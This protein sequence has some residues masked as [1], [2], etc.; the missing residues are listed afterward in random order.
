M[1]RFFL[2]SFS[3]FWLLILLLAFTGCRSSQSNSSDSEDI[4]KLTFLHINDVYEISG[5]SGG[6]YGNLARVAQLKKELLKENPN[7]YLVLSGDFLNPSVLGT[8]K[9]NEKRISGEQMVDVMNAAKVDFVTFGNHEFDLKEEEVLERINES[10]FEWIAS[11][12]FYY[13]NEKIQPFT[14]DG[15][16]LPTY[17]TIEPKNEAGKSIKVGIL[18]ITTKYNQPDFVRYTDEYETAKNIYTQIESET[19][20]TVALTHLLENEDKKLAGIVPE[21]KLLMGGHD[22]ENMKFTYGQTIMAK[23]DANARTAYIHRLTYNKKTNKL[24]IESELKTIDNSIGYEP[25]AKTAIEKWDTIADSVFD[26]QGFDVEREIYKLKEPLEAREALIRTTQTNAGT[27]IVDAMAYAFPD[28]ELA[29]LGSGSVRL[30]DQLIGTVTEYDILRMLPFGGKI[31]Q[32]TTSGDVLIQFLD[33]GIKNKGTGGYLQYQEKLKFDTKKG[34]LLNGQKIE[35]DKQYTLV[36]ND[37]NLSGKENNMAF[38]NKD[39]NEEI[40]N[41]ISSDDLDNP[42]SDIRKTVIVYLEKL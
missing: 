27:L 29:I 39:T 15:N 10:E 20:F 35:K 9:L 8:L 19:D 18:G 21:L 17:I 23:A 42:Q 14:R 22:H 2:F 11:N 6:K 26:A 25:T 24:H 41:V 30:D 31:Y 12:T 7:T 33:A 34:W 28:A 36:T 32:F 4:V 13:K 38:M 1:K 5:V 3:A 40:K 16:K 37:Y